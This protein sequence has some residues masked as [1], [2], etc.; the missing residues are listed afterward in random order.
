MRTDRQ[1]MMQIIG[2]SLTF[3]KV[4]SSSQFAYK[5]LR[6]ID[7]PINQK[8]PDYPYVGPIGNIR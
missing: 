3:F 7:C 5:R 4:Q 1:L 6:D 2:R 8:I